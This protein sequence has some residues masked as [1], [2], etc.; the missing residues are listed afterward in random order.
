MLLAW[1]FGTHFCGP[2][3]ALDRYSVHPSCSFSPGLPY[4]KTG[5]TMTLSR[6]GPLKTLEVIRPVLSTAS[7]TPP[8]APVGLLLSTRCEG[9][10]LLRTDLLTIVE[11]AAA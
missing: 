8:A 11:A 2:P 9:I 7:S 5:L 1:G 4:Q 10:A 3:L 6:Q